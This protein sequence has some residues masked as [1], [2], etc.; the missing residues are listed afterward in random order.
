MFLLSD[1]TGINTCNIEFHRIRRGNTCG[2]PAAKAA[3]RARLKSAG[4]DRVDYLECRD[5]ATLAPV[6]RLEA[7]GAVRLIDNVP[8]DDD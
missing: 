3:G 8:F 5:A 2:V 1:S 7:L 6:D 4:F